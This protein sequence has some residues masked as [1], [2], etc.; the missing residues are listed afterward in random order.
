MAQPIFKDRVKETSTTSG[1][2]T[3]T[4]NGAATGFQTFAAVG[5]GNT[6]YYTI[7]EPTGTSWEVGLGTYTAAGT[8]LSRDTVLASSNS[9]NKVNWDGGIKNV[10]LDVP[11]AWVADPIVNSITIGNSAFPFGE[12]SPGVQQ[13]GASAFT[14]TPATNT[15]LLDDGAAGGQFTTNSLVGGSA[16]S[17]TMDSDVTRAST[18]I[19]NSSG[20]ASIIGGIGSNLSI[21]ANGSTALTAVLSAIT[22]NAAGTIALFNNGGEWDIDAV[23]GALFPTGPLDVGKSASPLASGYFGTSVVTPSVVPSS[24]AITVGAGNVKVPSLPTSDPHVLGQLYTATVA[25]IGLIVRVSAG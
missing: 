16:G 6:C 23:T 11:A 5:D 22:M 10:F 20:V 18:I 9:N 1:T 13:L 12:F 8:T 2:G 4:L 19:L 15:L 21:A 17:L 7:E 24:G 3:L 25:T 14:L